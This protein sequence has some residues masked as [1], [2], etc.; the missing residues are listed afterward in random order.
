MHTTLDPH[1]NA[2]LE[3][4]LKRMQAILSQKLVGLYLYGSTVLGDYTDKVSDLDLL[5]ALS[6]DL[7]DAEAEAI[8]Q[9]HADIVAEFPEWDDRIEVQYTSTQSLAHFKAQ[10]HV[11]GNI[12]P[13][14]PFHIIEA[15]AEWLVNWYF[16]Q[17]YGLVLY[18]APAA[19]IIPP[20][21]EQDFI[22]A[23]REHILMWREYINDL[24]E[25]HGSQA[26]AIMT[27][28]R[29]LYTVTHREHV[30]KQKSADWGIGAYPQWAELIRNAIVWRQAQHDPTARYPASLA[31]TRRFVAFM[32]EEMERAV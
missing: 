11:M 6:S 9:M 8:R 28:C 3:I 25:W 30:S 22:D 20:L 7:S 26:Y 4:L 10:R 21:T 24:S 1:V 15:G 27:M 5:A 23:V 29:G 19:D 31:E 32:I 14:E 17:T 18:G 2:V 12:S 16:V 13:G